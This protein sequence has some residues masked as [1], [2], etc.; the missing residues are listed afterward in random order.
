MKLIARA[1]GKLV[2]SG[3]YAVLEG[4]PAIVTAVDRYATADASKS[5]A[6]ITPEV[7][8][9][10][11]AR[12]LSENEAPFF[13]ASPL[14]ADDR[15]LGLG[16][17]AAILVA[18]LAAIELRDA[19]PS[20][21][22]E[23]D[24]ARRILRP[25]ITAHRLAQ[26][27]GSGIDVVTSALGGTQR[28]VLGPD[29]EIT[30]APIPWPEGLHFEVWSS[31]EAASTAEMLR[32]V[33]AFRDARPAEYRALLRSLGDAAKSAALAR[34]PLAFLEALKAQASLLDALGRAA[35]AP[36]V[37][38]A[39]A[40]LDALAREGGGV[41]IPSG[42]G[43]GDIALFFGVEPPSPQLTRAAEGGGLGRLSL[44]PGARGVHAPFLP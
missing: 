7:R 39:T 6:F 1:P 41:M 13:D 32:K 17:S 33:R 35:G 30:A 27:G 24:L 18:S 29:G 4:A 43:G 14:R 20:L 9:A 40:R 26:G 2:I 23:G 36:I 22:K 15:K 38:D 28:C 12:G 3:A 25:A 42:A 10:L 21:L 44:T 5:P 19:S 31:P 16:S 8:E 11:N 37:T 34:S